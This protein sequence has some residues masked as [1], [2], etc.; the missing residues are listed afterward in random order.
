MKN[1]L[2]II[3]LIVWPRQRCFVPDLDR[4][5]RKVA[6]IEVSRRRRLA[7]RKAGAN[8]AKKVVASPHAVDTGIQVHCRGEGGGGGGVSSD[9]DDDEGVVCI[10]TDMLGVCG[11]AAAPTSA[12]AFHTEGGKQKPIPSQPGLHSIAFS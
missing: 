12:Q 10:R 8:L 7:G 2:K 11:G 4:G 9:D 6:H 3:G 5:S 1:V